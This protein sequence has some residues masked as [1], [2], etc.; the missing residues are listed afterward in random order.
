[1]KE[2]IVTTS[3]DDGHPLDLRLAEMLSKYDI[4]AT[5]Y[6]PVER[7]KRGCMNTGEIQEISRGFDIGG[8]TYN[9]V[10]LP[11]LSVRDAE[12][13]IVDS[14]VKLEEITGKGLTSFCYPY[15][16]YNARITSIVKAAGFLGARTMRSLTR[17]IDDPYEMGTTIYANDWWF[18]PYVRHS[19]LSR[20]LR[21]LS[22][23]VRNNLFFKG[24]NDIAVGTLN[25]VM[26]NGGIWHLWGH[27][28][29]ID[30]NDDWRKL[31]AVLSLVSSLAKLA[32]KV[33][34]SQLLMMRTWER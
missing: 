20:D 8:H 27:S 13:E 16:E 17:R 32:I 10:H 5:F 6:I 22:F 26:E 24:W 1:M 18:A 25:F 31:E 14:K 34:N 29:E 4:P 15:G 28:W 12:R 9:H 23:M 33:D 2:A 11:L 7:V 19:L 3:W 30:S 21:L